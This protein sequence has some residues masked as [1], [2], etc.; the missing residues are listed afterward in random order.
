[1]IMQLKIP[2]EMTVSLADSSGCVH[3]NGTSARQYVA[4]NLAWRGIAAEVDVGLSGFF[5]IHNYYT[6]SRPQGSLS[7]LDG[8]TYLSFGV[9]DATAASRSGSASVDNS[10]PAIDP[11]PLREHP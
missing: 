7:V 3:S 1:M 9:S 10:N 2:G 6:P 5:V 8:E 11:L 4:K